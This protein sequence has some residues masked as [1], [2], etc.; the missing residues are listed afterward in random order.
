M[1]RLVWRNF[2]Q[3]RGSRLKREQTLAIGLLSLLLSACD[4]PASQQIGVISTSDAQQEQV[5]RDLAQDVIRALHLRWQEQTGVMT[6]SVEDFCAGL[7]SLKDARF[8]FSQAADAWS[9]LQPVL[10]GPLAEHNLAWR[11]QFWP[12][13]KNLVGRQVEQLLKKNPAPDVATLEKSS[14]VIQ[15]LSA[16]EYIL[17]DPSIDLAERATQSRYCPLLQSIAQNQQNLAG[18]VLAQLDAKDGLLTAFAAFPNERYADPMEAISELMRVNVTALDSLKKKLGTPLGRLNKGNLQPMQAEFWRSDL[19]LASISATLSASLA[20]WQGN[21]HL[22]LRDLLKGSEHEALIPRI[23]AAF[24][25]VKQDLG[26]GGLGNALKD[27]AGR[28]QLNKLYDSLN[29]LHRLHQ[30]ELVTAL[31]IQLGFNASDGD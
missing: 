15:G 7:S 17:F 11:V 13:K 29:R 28:A 30:Q 19:G 25:D 6:K 18:S 22:G 23:D 12:D 21:T 16:A 2:G 1:L 8:G 27:E 10:I 3:Q 31:G 9:F 20:L 5:T 26:A 4:D 24:A 14:V